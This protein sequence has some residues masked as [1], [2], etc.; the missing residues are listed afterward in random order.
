MRVDADAR[1][2]RAFTSL[3]VPGVDLSSGLGWLGGSSDVLSCF[4]CPFHA[5]RIS[6]SASGVKHARIR[7][8]L[9]TNAVAA[10]VVLGAAQTSPY[11]DGVE[12]QPR[13]PSHGVGQGDHANLNAVVILGVGEAHV[14]LTAPVLKSKEAEVPTASM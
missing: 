5:F 8:A 14:G 1:N 3:P 11:R 2:C 4:G 12:L 7:A 9:V 6:G 10:S 13:V